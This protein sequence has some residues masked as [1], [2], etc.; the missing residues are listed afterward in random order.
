MKP[1]GV[2]VAF[3]MI[4]LARSLHANGGGY[5]RGGL[6]NTGDVAGFEPKATENIRILDEKLTIRLGAKEADVEVRYLMRNVTDRKV[7]VRFGFPVEESFDRNL[8]GGP[9]PEKTPDGKRLSYCKNYQITAAGKAVPF[10]WQGEVRES[11]EPPFKGVAGWLISEVSFAANE[12]KPLM[13]RFQ[14]DYPSEVWGV[15]DDGSSSAARFRYR[16]STAACW[17]GSIGTGKIIV[18]PSGID[19]S[20]ITVIRPVN[21]FRKDGTRWIW[22]FENLEPTLADDIEIEARPAEFTFG[23][24]TDNGEFTN[25]DTPKHRLADIIN[26]G[27]QWSM[28]HS[29]YQVTASSTLPADGDIHYKAENIRD[30]WERNTWSEGAPGPGT[31]EWLEMVPASPKPLLG[32]RMKPGYQ[33]KEGL[34]K[35]NARPKKIRVELN[36]EHRFDA[37]VAD[38]EEEITIPVVDY[39]KPVKKIRMTFLEIYPGSRFEDLCVSSVRLHVRLAKKPNVQ[40]AR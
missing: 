4:A 9:D 7:K 20:D 13:I 36:G 15:S 26:R 40:P 38:R 16:L 19:P 17:A 11:K 25:F 39:A 34:F 30:F 6:E 28:M 21:R 24:R 5:F 3:C 33:G 31:G 2:L 18:E 37:E 8:M 35:A 29:N 27:S 14:S 22:N 32:I 12:E 23:G 1:V 10:K